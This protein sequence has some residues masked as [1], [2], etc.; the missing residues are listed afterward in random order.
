MGSWNAVDDEGAA[1]TLW[2]GCPGA[3][4]R[5]RL[6]PLS[7]QEVPVII[8]LP[9]ATSKR[10]GCR[11]AG[12][13]F[14][15]EDMLTD[16]NSLIQLPKREGVAIVNNQWPASTAVRG[17]EGSLDGLYEDNRC[18]SPNVGACVTRDR[19]VSLTPRSLGLHRLPT[20]WFRL[21]LVIVASTPRSVL[22]SRCF[23]H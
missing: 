7:S 13:C 12:R 19:R 21:A 14:A 11:A 3:D 10:C 22:R 2:R 8:I 9:P 17:A 6:F 15:R 1:G 5:G 20:S 23:A 18:P 4:G 16:G